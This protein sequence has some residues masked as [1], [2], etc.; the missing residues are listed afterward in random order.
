M[1]M[2]PQD[3]TFVAFSVIPA[4]CTVDIVVEKKE[5]INSSQ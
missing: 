2:R 3:F 5:K 4:V 1:V